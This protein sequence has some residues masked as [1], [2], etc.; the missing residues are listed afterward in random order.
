MKRD[1][2][3]YLLSDGSYLATV[4]RIEGFVVAERATSDTFRPIAVGTAEASVDGELLS[5][6][7]KEGFIML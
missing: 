2:L 4:R 1:A 7:A 3:V 6:S 5:P